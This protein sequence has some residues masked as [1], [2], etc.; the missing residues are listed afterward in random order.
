MKS[1]RILALAA[2]AAIMVGACSSSGGSPSLSAAA[3]TAAGSAAASAPP[4]ASASAAASAPA[5]P[6]GPTALA[7]IGPGEGALNLV[8][9]TGY[10]VGGTGGEQV[11]GYDWVTPFETATGCKVTSRSASTPGTWSS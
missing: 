9:W 10:V 6:S 4:S 8:A 2:T 3:P 1:K 5:A 7:S 11:Q